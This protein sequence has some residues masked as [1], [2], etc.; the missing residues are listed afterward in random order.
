MNLQKELLNFIES[1]IRNNPIRYYTLENGSTGSKF[2]IGLSITGTYSKT[3]FKKVQIEDLEIR[4]YVDRGTVGIWMK[5]EER[6]LEFEVSREFP[7]LELY[8]I[9]TTALIENDIKFFIEGDQ[10]KRDC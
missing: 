8:D 7:F 10:N 9:V 4:L 2:M 1:D 3:Y 6:T 5:S